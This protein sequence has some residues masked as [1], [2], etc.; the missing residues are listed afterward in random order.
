MGFEATFDVLIRGTSDATFATNCAEMESEFSKRRQLLLVQMNSQTVGTYNP[1]DGTNT[2][3]NSYARI[4]K[5]GTPGADTDRSRLYTVTVGCELPATD[6]SGRR[7]SSLTVEYDPAQGR[8]VTIAGTWTALTTLNATAQYAAQI[9]AFCTSALSALLPAGTFELVSQRTERDDQDKTLKFSR[10]F[11]EIYI[12]QPSGALDNA[13][14]VE[15]KLMFA[16]SKDQ[17]GD[18]G[19]GKVKRLEAIHGRFECWLDKTVSTD[20]ATLYTGTILPYMKSELASRFQ[21]VQFAIVSERPSFTPYTNQFAVEIEFACSIDPT[22]V[23]E[24]ALTSMIIENSGVVLTGAWSGG[25]FDKYVDQGHGTKRR[26]GKRIVRVLGTLGPKSRLGGGGTV[27]GIDGDLK[28][29]GDGGAGGH[30][31][32]AGLQPSGGGESAKSGWILID[33]ESSAT[34][35]WIGQPN[36]DQIAV[37]DLVDQTVEEWVDKP[38]G[39]GGTG[40]QP[41]PGGSV[42]G[43]AR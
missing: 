18:S 12:A 17:P 38:S 26:I 43:I 29:I 11:R 31:S 40:L 3:L 23:I 8:T 39:G 21:P 13:S 10:V 37:T 22:D 4:D 14:I 42:G 16:R 25:L 15:P 20:L 30:G 27:E 19:G 6:T 28:W 36:G 5:V 34:P 32:G 24:S 9:A 41:G 2:G 35:K 7:D 1:A 33:S